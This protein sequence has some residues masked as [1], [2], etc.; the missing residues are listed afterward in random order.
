MRWYI[1]A[2]IGLILLFIVSYIYSQSAVKI[3]KI[4][5]EEKEYTQFVVLEGSIYLNNGGF[6]PVRMG[7][8]YYFVNLEGQEILRGDIPGRFISPGSNRLYFSDVLRKFPLTDPSTTNG[9]MRGY[10]NLFDLRFI[11]SSIH[12]EKN[13][14][15]EKYI[16]FRGVILE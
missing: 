14:S 9:T 5:V 11:D 2:I 6:V 3:T 10:V 12:Y 16:R 8:T 7:G 15:L 1:P 4:E 13:I